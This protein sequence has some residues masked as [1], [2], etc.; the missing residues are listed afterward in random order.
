MFSR[1]LNALLAGYVQA[2]WDLPDFVNISN[3][4]DLINLLRYIDS[5]ML[6]IRDSMKPRIYNV[7]SGPCFR[8]GFLQDRK[9][10]SKNSD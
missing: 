5:M 2:R 9:I 6:W 1:V 3:C 10:S 7:N 4:S 8:R